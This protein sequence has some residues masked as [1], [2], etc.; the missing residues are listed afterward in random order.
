MSKSSTFRRLRQAWAG[1][2]VAAGLLLAFALANSA[3]AADISLC[4]SSG[5]VGGIGETSG[6]VSGP[7]DG[8]CGDDSAVMV[9]I[10]QST[11]YGKVAFTA[12]TPGFPT[13]VPLS[14]L[15]SLSSN[16]LFSGPSNAQPFYMLAFT[17]SSKSLG[18]SSATDQIL[19]IEFQPATLSGTTMAANPGS[20]LFNLY[21]NTT[22]T[23]LLGGQQ[24]T[25]TLNAWLAD[26]PALDDDVLQGIWIGVGLTG[27]NAGPESFTL[28][29]FDASDDIPEPASLTILSVALVGLGVGR[30]TRAG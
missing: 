16:V 20:T 14:G 2:A 7:L 28:N 3:R 27:G 19:L 25:N 23:Y 1:S 22:N 12:G 21:D 26:D 17:D 6:D 15:V 10:T 4:P 8:T 11:Q 9:S 13:G 24:D 5:V 18:Q 30:H 29:S